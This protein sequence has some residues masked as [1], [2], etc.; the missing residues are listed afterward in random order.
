M[1]DFWLVSISFNTDPQRPRPYK[2]VVKKVTWGDNIEKGDYPK[3]K[4]KNFIFGD[5][6]LVILK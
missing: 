3:N 1:Y 2:K 5:S 4:N 6:W